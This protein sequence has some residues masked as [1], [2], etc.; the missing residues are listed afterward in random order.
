MFES[1]NRNSP[2]PQHSKLRASCDTCFLAKVKCSK[3]R[4]ICS[5]CLSCGADC[6]YSPSSRAGKPKSDGSKATQSSVSRDVL[7]PQE[8][9]I[10]TIDHT[11]SMDVDS[12][13]SVIYGAEI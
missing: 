11:K 2:K 12:E 1:T 5:R 7:I 3:T 13:H 4:P 8:P 6:N 9:N 10:S